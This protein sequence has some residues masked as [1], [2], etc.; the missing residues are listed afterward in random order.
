MIHTLRKR[1]LLPVVAPAT[2]LRCISRVDFYQVGASFCRFACQ[3]IEKSRPRGITDAFGKAMVMHH[4]INGQVFHTDETVG[5][6]D[7]MTFLMR[8]VLST[9]GN[10]LMYPRY[11]VAMLAPLGRTLLKFAMSALYLCQCRF[12]RA[13]ETGIGNLFTSGKRGKGFQTY[14]NTDLLS[15]LRQTLRFALNRKA[16][17]PFAGTTSVNG[18]RLDL[19]L[20]GAMIDHLDAPDLRENDTIIMG[21][22][23]L[24]RRQDT[25]T[26]LREG[27]TIIAITPAKA[28]ITGVLTGLDSAKERLHGEVNPHSNI[29]Q[30]L[31][32]N[33]GE[34]RTLGF[35]Y[36][37]RGLLLIARKP[38]AGLLIRFL[39]FFKQVIVEP[40]AFIKGRIQL[41]SL[42]FC[43]VYPVLKHLL[44]TSIVAQV[45]VGVNGL[46]KTLPITPH[47]ERPFIPRLKDGGFLA[48][49]V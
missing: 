45:Y 21:S 1:H 12:F 48:R 30:D 20:D 13:K 25:K 11:H 40:S 37:I 26:T 7:T 31:R 46:L 24:A 5:V 14:V 42:L 33:T 36:R 2:V 6:D 32:M 18:T 22:A 4:A 10:P 27:E 41:C 23:P 43:W 38:F 39:A 47:K 16:D 44:H 49:F 34:R 29:L 28:G 9:E 35:Q 15:V 3:L 19:A 17:V 8:E